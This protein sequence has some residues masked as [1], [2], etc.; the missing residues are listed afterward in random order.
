M[1]LNELLG[2]TKV[3]YEV[4]QNYLNFLMLLVS[5]ILVTWQWLPF[6]ICNVIH[7]VNRQVSVV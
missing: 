3:I 5:L 7:L 2:Q 4:I 1:V 6:Q